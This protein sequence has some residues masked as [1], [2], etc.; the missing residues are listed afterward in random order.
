MGATLPTSNP[1]IRV[2]EEYAML[3]TVGDRAGPRY[4]APERSHPRRTALGRAD[5]TTNRKNA[6]D[7]WDSRPGAS[8]RRRELLLALATGTISGRTVRAQQKAMPVIGI[9]SVFSPPAN[10]G[11]LVRGPVH[12]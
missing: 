7:P 2:A 10:L 9:L 4:A 5:T 12:E 11:D 1:P 8:I 3:D 6:R